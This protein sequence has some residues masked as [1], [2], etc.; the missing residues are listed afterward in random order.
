MP[1]PSATSVVEIPL[2]PARIDVEAAHAFLRATYW[3]Q[4]IPLAVLRR[5]IAHALC[6]AAL[7]GGVQ[8]GFARA[9]GIASVGRRG[10]CPRLGPRR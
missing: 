4:D 9:E 2:D 3:A 1:E 10:R 6:V 5:A 8:V 7:E